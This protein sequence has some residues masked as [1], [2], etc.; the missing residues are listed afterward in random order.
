MSKTSVQNETRNKKYR[1]EKR[2]KTT[3]RMKEKNWMCF[4]IKINDPA[5]ARERE[6]FPLFFIIVK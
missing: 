4:F 5:D 3:D 2:A 6:H 1:H